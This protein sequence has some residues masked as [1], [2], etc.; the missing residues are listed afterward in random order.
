MQTAWQDCVQIGEHTLYHGDCLEVLPELDPFEGINHCISDPP[1]EAEA[2]RADRRVTRKGGAVVAERLSF[3]EIGDDTRFR[4]ALLLKEMTEGWL[5]L[6][7]QAE[8]VALWRDAI[9]AAG[10]K[11]KKPMIWVKPD[12]M[13]QF[14][15]QGPGMGYESMVTA[16][17]GQGHS[18]WNGGGRHGVFTVSKGS[19][20]EI[21]HETQKPQRLMGM[22]VELFTNP[23]EKI[24]DPFM[25]SGS[26]G[27]AAARLGR[28]FIGIEKDRNYFEVA[29]RR[30]QS[31]ERQGD[32][33]V[34]RPRAGK[35]E[36]LL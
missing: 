24:I 4:V 11:Y 1:Y 26:T 15:G 16:W 12:G 36:N 2:H 14:N 10:A 34:E 33:F 32:L 27:V 7:C 29:C 20:P 23:G 35:Q 28:R 18:R 3:G 8:G 31:A 9:V 19:D 13:P 25:G 22:L 17:T 5:I 6:F 30:L 21:F